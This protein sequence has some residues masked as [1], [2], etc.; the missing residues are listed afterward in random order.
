MSS[1]HKPRLAAGMEQDLRKKIVA[2]QPRV[3]ERLASER[4]LCETY[5][6]SRTVVREAIA[7]L[8]AAGLIESRRGSGLYVKS[9]KPA[10]L[11]GLPSLSGMSDEIIAIVDTLELRAAVEIEAAFL[12]ATR[13]SPG[14]IEKIRACQRD[15]SDALSKG[16]ETEGADFDFHQA[17]ADATN[18]PAYQAFMKYLGR[19]TIPRSKL[20][21]VPDSKAYQSYLVDMRAEHEEILLAIERQAAEEA[22]QAMRAHLVGSLERYRALSRG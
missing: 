16:G 4:V 9:D 18:N 14:Q 22:R 19:Q 17:I 15:Y 13:A 3:G 20:G 5:G 2:G 8:R 11:E 21:F 12:A 6:V 10:S 1:K 7:G